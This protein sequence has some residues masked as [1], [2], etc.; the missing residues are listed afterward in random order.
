[1]KFRLLFHFSLLLLLVTEAYRAYLLMPIPG[2][3]H[4]EM[5]DISW[6]LWHYR[7]II[8]IVLFVGVIAGTKSVFQKR[9]WI[10]IVNLLFTGFVFYLANFYMTA[11]SMFHEPEN[12]QFALP[13][14]SG[15][16]MDALVIGVT[17]GGESHAYPVRYLSFH[18]QVHDVVGGQDVLVTYC[19]VCRSGMVFDPVREGWIENFRLVGMD[20]FNAMF[21]DHSTGSWWMQANG[22]CVAGELKG[23][24]LAVV[25][26][27]Q[28]TLAEWVQ[29]HPGGKVMMA[30]PEYKDDYDDEKFEKGTTTSSLEYTDT[31]SWHDKSWVIGIEMNGAYRA[32][33]W[34]QLKRERTI[35][36]NLGGEE[37]MI[38]IDDE[39]INY[40]AVVVS[41][42]NP[43]D[44]INGSDTVFKVGYHPGF[45]VRT[46]PARQLF[47]HTW[48]TFY[49]NTTQYPE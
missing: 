30:D 45:T 17:D 10:P 49:P 42:E 5:V 43:V 21:E 13:A 36:D 11:E 24:K 31:A 23:Q 34:N 6:F 27:E 46:I 38:T 4:S 18:H 35:H 14:D 19:S 39:N 22:E 1:M 32:Y 20:Q 3:Q 2:S 7:W 37:I 47:W 41:Q 44:S 48:R 25:P 33:D 26:F 9:K 8:R 29:R 16:P 12:L 15:V 28:M 40:E